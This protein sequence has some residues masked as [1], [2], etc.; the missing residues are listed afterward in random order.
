M[1]KPANNALRIDKWLWAARFYKT[2]QLAVKAIKNNQIQL[3]NQPV[4][5]SSMLKVED[6]LRIK[7]GLFEYQFTVLALSE[8]RRCATIAQSLYKETADSIR[9]REQLKQQLDS[10]PKITIEPRKPNKR[11]IRDHRSLKRGE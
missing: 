7:R 9:T 10:Q 5:P 1:P 3:N 11:A 4:K 6:R 2:R 8:Q